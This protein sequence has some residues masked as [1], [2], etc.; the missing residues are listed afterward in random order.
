MFS[1]ITFGLILSVIGFSISLGGFLHAIISGDPK[2]N[3]TIITCT[4]FAALI[5]V[6]GLAAYS[7]YAYE[8]EIRNAEHSIEATLNRR[9]TLSADQLY[10]E[11]FPLVEY[12]VLT[13]ALE[14]L[15]KEGAVLQRTEEF[16]LKGN[17]EIKV[18][19]YYSHG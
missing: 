9:V 8:A 7:W 1:N 16:N 13:E 3:K 14:R 4:S 10:A 12:P 15:V 6:S 2:T 19:V 11:V 5:V 18:R 17:S